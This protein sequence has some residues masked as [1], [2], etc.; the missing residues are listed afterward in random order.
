MF[1]FNSKNEV[2]LVSLLL[3][4]N[5][6]HNFGCVSIADFEQVSISCTC[7]EFIKETP[8]RPLKANIFYDKFQ[9]LS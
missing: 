2:T 5:I 8:K 3:T 6:F 9:T 7:S 1:K 4:S